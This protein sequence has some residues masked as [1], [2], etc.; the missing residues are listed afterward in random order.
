MMN[1]SRNFAAVLILS[2]LFAFS[3]AAAP[4][5]VR[6]STNPA[7]QPTPRPSPPP[8]PSASPS[9]SPNPS[10]APSPKPTPRPIVYPVP[11][12]TLPDEPEEP[13][14]TGS[15]LLDD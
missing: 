8:A 11:P 2:L 6:K 9:P 1:F 12:A 3:A 4:V 14:S 5:V 13:E 7:C 10:P 15:E